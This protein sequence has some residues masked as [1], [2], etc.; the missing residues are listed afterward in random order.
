MVRK[1][2]F[3]IGRDKGSD[4]W[5]GTKVL[6]LIGGALIHIIY[7]M[8]ILFSFFHDKD[9]ALLLAEYSIFNLTLLG[10]KNIKLNNRSDN[11]TENIRN[12]TDQATKKELL[13]ESNF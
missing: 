6:G 5:S 13:E 2:W 9:V 4:K 1:F 8:I 10:Y 11:R 7:V 12:Q 3:D